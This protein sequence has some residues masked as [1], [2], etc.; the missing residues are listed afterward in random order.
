MV[1]RPVLI[2]LRSLFALVL[3][4]SIVL[5]TNQAKAADPDLTS[6][7]AYLLDR[8]TALK[9]SAEALQTAGETYYTLAETAKF[10]YVALSK[11]EDFV[12][13]VKV[14]R[15]AWI[16]A[17]PLYEQME[18]I[19][20]GVPALSEYDPRLDA[21]AEGDVDFD[22]T[23]PDG[24]LLEKPGN[25][26]GLLEATLWGTREAFTTEVEIDLDGDE[27]IGFGDRLPS[28]GHLKAFADAM[29]NVAAEL[30]EAAIAWEP[31]MTDAF[32]ALVVMIPTMKEYFAS[33]KESRFVLG[34]ESTQEDFNII[35]RLADIRDILSGLIIV[36]DTVSPSV[37]AVDAE[38]DTLI[39]EGLADL[40]KYVEDL[41]KEEQDGKRFTPEEADLFGTEAQ[42]RAENL[43]G[44]VA[45][46]AGQLDITLPE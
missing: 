19:V 35:S 29:A 21:G 7:K 1:I 30:D 10:D 32:T 33:W 23:L 2:T 31:N 46:V 11:D 39:K 25:L 12:N 42:T 43:V 16:V 6:I 8:T 17:S 14:A 41:L 15:E 28:A 13:L 27:K 45:Q 3:I 36:Y 26:F 22:I 5:T 37:V 40:Y 9:E 38:R 24:T 4:L 18:G 20:A 34:E 44:L